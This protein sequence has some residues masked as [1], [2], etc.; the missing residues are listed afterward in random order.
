[1]ECVSYF[2]LLIVKGLLELLK[3]DKDVFFISKVSVC[4]I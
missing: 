4:G 3:S 1:M 2:I